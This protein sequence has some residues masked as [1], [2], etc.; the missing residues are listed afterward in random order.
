ME[1]TTLINVKYEE[2]GEL[3]N[4]I[5]D[6]VNALTPFGIKVTEATGY[7]ELFKGNIDIKLEDNENIINIA[8]QLK[9]GPGSQDNEYYYIRS[10][11]PN[12]NTHHLG[13]LDEMQEI[14]SQE[15]FNMILLTSLLKL[16]K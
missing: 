3:D 4:V 5:E 10:I 9:Q 6:F 12:G 15:D 8:Y 2:S 11:E 1:N 16:I 7:F 13:I 14:G